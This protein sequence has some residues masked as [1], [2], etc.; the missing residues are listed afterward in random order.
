MKNVWTSRLEFHWSLTLRVQLTIGIGSGNGLAPNRRQAITWTNEDL[1]LCDHM[2][3]VGHSG[4]SQ[5]GVSQHATAC[6]LGL[7][8]TSRPPSTYIIIY[9]QQICHPALMFALNEVSKHKA[10]INSLHQKLTHS[11]FIY[12]ELLNITEYSLTRSMNPRALWIWVDSHVALLTKFCG[13]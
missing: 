4:L 8:K 9:V 13:K 3:S 5:N 6:L 7:K 2:V 12:N 10:R 11:L 1:D